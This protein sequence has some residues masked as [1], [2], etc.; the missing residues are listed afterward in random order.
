MVLI[1]V[2]IYYSVFTLLLLIYFNL[3]KTISSRFQMIIVQN[4]S[5]D[6][7]VWLNLGFYAINALLYWIYTQRYYHF[8]WVNFIREIFFFLKSSCREMSQGLLQKLKPIQVPDDLLRTECTLC[9]EKYNLVQEVSR[10]PCRHCFHTECIRLW[11]Y[12]QRSCPLCRGN[13]IL[14]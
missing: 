4:L 12:Q 7:C 10:L 14:Y 2:S 13:V 5:Y 9:L 1:L 3:N 11:L 8:F 6:T